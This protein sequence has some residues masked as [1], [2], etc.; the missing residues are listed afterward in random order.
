MY[1]IN[2]FIANPRMRSN[3]PDGNLIGLDH[4]S[5]LVANRLAEED[6]MTLSDEHWQVIYCLRERFRL[7]GPDWTAR[8]MTH[9]LAREYADVGGRRYLYELFPHGPIAQACRLAGLPLPLG[10]ISTSFGSV[11]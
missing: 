4:W 6:G 7:L 2:K 8:R 11:H 5:P 9:E 10:T 3:D 1:D